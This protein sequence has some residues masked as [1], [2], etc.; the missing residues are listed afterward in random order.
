MASVARRG[1]AVLFVLVATTATAQGLIQ[2]GGDIDRYEFQYGTPI[3]VT[4]DDLLTNP[5]SY[6][7]RAVKT[8]GKLEMGMSLQQSYLM[9]E[10]FGSVTVTPVPEAE[11][12]FKMD[13]RQWIGR[14]VDV[15][16]VFGR[17]R[18]D[19]TSSTQPKDSSTGPGGIAEESHYVINFWKYLGPPE[20][21]Q[22]GA[23]IKADQ[24]TL[25]DLVSKAG[26][27]D[28][29]TV[30]VVGKFR[31]RNL[32]GD[33][34][35]RSERD[36][37]DWVIKDDVYAVW[38][39]GKRPKGT[40]W[41]LDLGLKRDTAKWV[42]VVGRPE[43]VGNVTYI[44][45]LSVVLGG[46]PR[47]AAEAAPPPPP[48][49]RP[50]LPPV[51]VFSLPLDG[52]RDVPST[53]LF[54][55]QFSK[56]MDEDSFR[57]H[58]VFRYAGPR[59]PGDREFVGLKVSYDGGRRAL[60]VD[61]GDVLRPGRVVELRLLSGIIDVDGLP[62]TPRPGHEPTAATAELLRFEVASSSALLPGS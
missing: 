29:K 31:G 58:I 62:L 41:E 27:L 47:A 52:E 33:L 57:G 38:I 56:D 45:A 35:A 61:P 23:L 8:K 3:A 25:E 5:G 6:E 44:R 4:L 36:S 18:P 2:S 50:K 13:A 15:T 53:G 11:E 55:V 16:G 32:F 51:V 21:E 10:M 1:T 37:S 12:T 40:G 17:T 9:R 42:E 49:P 26:K 54:K 7:G 19:R 30:R 60:I 22:K 20:R 59:L 24:V 34:P 14:E 43:T 28:G 39:T 46:P 48:P